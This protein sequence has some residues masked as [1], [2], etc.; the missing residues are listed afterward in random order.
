MLNEIIKWTALAATLSGAVCTSL[1][2]DPMNVYLLNLGSLLYLTWSIR[3]KDT[4][5]ICV[6][7]G[8]MMIYVVGIFRS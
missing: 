8:L 6:N 7:A 5:L 2:I 4:N 1:R 3:V